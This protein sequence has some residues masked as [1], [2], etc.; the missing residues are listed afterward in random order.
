MEREVGKEILADKEIVR[1]RRFKWRGVKIAQ[2]TTLALPA[3][4]RLLQS[5]PFWIIPSKQKL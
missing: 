5:K 4:E 1:R 3:F 2:G